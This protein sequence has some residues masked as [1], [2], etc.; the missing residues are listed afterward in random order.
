[1]LQEIERKFRV[2]NTTFLQETTSKFKIVQGYLNSNPDRTVR[3]RL[4]EN[5]AFITVKGKSNDAG[6]TR[7]EW[8]K[9]INYT[10]AEQLIQL[11]EDFIIEKIRYEVTYLNQLFEIDI[12]EGKNTGLI[13][14]EIELESPNQKVVF[15]DWLGKEVT[16][17]VRFYNAYLSKNPYTAWQISSED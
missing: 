9:E 8:E 16:G 4:K 1:M 6:T 17:D 2:K 3:I 14:A 11:C 10:E 12:F 15:P 5:K 13:I 7:F